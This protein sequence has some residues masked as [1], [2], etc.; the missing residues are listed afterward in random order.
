MNK[1]VFIIP[2]FNEEKRISKHEFTLAFNEF[3]EIDFLL[4]NDGSSDGTQGIIEHFSQLFENVKAL[5]LKINQG[6]AEAIRAGIL[7]CKDFNYSYFGY[8][9]ADLST[10][11]SEVKKLLDFAKVNEN[12][13]IV[14]GTRI[15][16]L[17]NNVVRSN[18]RHYL[19]RIFATIISKFILQTPVYDTQCGAKIISSSVVFDLFKDK[20]ET[21]WLFDVEMLLRLK[22]KSST[23]EGCVAEIPLTTWIE[24]G[25]TKIKFKEFINFPFQLILIYFKNDK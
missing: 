24:K 7:H 4:V 15:K 25:N 21:R 8:L 16:L 12:L 22:K 11:V 18:K 6:K 13:K 23:L 17:G 1:A 19:G 3:S 10:P 9:D 14:M 2:F 20:F 5:S